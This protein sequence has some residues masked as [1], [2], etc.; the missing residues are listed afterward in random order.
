MGRVI[1]RREWLS[2]WGGWWRN[3]SGEVRAD[4]KRAE[5]TDGASDS[6]RARIAPLPMP[7]EKSLRDLWPPSI[8]SGKVGQ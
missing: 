1:S 8:R 7:R 6:E 3:L 2:G 4:G 5:D